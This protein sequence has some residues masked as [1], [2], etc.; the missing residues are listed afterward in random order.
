MEKFIKKLIILIPLLFTLIACS[1]KPMLNKLDTTSSILAFGD[2]LTF[3]Y[4]AAKNESYPAVLSDLTGLSVINAGING[5]VSSEGLKRLEALL[6]K[7]QPQLLLL[8]H[9]AN[10]MLQK[11]DLTQMADN[12]IA[13][14]NL[15]QHRDIDVLLIAVPNTNI[16]L[17]PLKQYQQVAD[18]MNIPLEND[19]ISD[20][21]SQPS[22]HSD[23]IHP[24]A[25]GYRQIAETIHQKLINLGAI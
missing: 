2:S 19:L 3:G 17:T 25:M 14:I 23:L 15:A 20:I 12:L 6:D 16:L 9:G 11:Q 22:L 24:N 13:M 7:H 8:C 4:G 21:L 18:E 1:D 10:D 5:E